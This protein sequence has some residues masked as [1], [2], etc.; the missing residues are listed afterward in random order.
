MS[1]GAGFDKTDRSGKTLQFIDVQVEVGFV[2]STNGTVWGDSKSRVLKNIHEQRKQ[3]K[4]DTRQKA[5]RSNS[6][7]IPVPTKNSV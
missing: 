1:R 7:A 4:E 5:V 6:P 3:A 2:I